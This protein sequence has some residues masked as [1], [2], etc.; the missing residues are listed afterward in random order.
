MFC[1]AF[2]GSFNN[3]RSYDGESWARWEQYAPL[4]GDGETD[5]AKEPVCTEI[6]YRVTLTTGGQTIIAESEPIRIEL[7][8]TMDLGFVGQFAM[9]RIEEGNKMEVI[10]SDIP[11]I[12]SFSVN[13]CT[14]D[15]EC[16]EET[17]IEGTDKIFVREVDPCREYTVT[18]TPNSE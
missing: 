17:H 14:E 5:A 4:L 18:I 16:E 8:D 11:C 3:Y 6:R 12:E 13:I 9:E 2:D 10:W 7:D 15:G 1:N